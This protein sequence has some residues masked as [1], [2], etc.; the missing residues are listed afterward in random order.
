MEK[1]AAV[2]VVMSPLTGSLIQRCLVEGQ[3][4]CWRAS[5]GNNAVVVTVV[6]NSSMECHLFEGWWSWCRAPPVRLMW[7]DVK[8]RRRETLLSSEAS[9]GTG[10]AFRVPREQQLRLLLHGPTSKAGT[11]V[12]VKRHVDQLRVALLGRRLA[13]VMS[14][15]GG[16]R[17]RCRRCP[18]AVNSQPHLAPPGPR[19]VGWL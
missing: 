3:W 17:R 16:E 10:M 4:A 9:S 19:P 8:P 13:G 15:L 14:G 2:A 7:R 11:S 5:P 6:I 12:F 1:D 18:V